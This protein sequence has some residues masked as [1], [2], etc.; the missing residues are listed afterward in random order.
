MPLRNCPD[1]S[2]NRSWTPTLI[3]DDMTKELRYFASQLLWLGAV[4]SLLSLFSGCTADHQD[5]LSSYLGEL[6]DKTRQHWG[7]PIVDSMMVPSVQNGTPGKYADQIFEYRVP[8]GQCLGA[9]VCHLSKEIETHDRKIIIERDRY[10]SLIGGDSLF[11]ITL[12]YGRDFRRQCPWSFEIVK[13]PF[14]THVGLME[15]LH[16]INRWEIPYPLI[17]KWISFMQQSNPNGL[18]SIM[19]ASG[20]PRYPGGWIEVPHH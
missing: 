16:L 18:N 13:K 10:Q 19:E 12:V 15:A 14:G 9:N 5:E 11:T 1:K 6:G 3:V 8:H 7:V 17:S 4:V 2:D 20:E